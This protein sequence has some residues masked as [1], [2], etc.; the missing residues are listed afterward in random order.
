MS[1]VTSPCIWR[2]Y[3]WRPQAKGVVLGVIRERPPC[4]F[5]ISPALC[6]QG[7]VVTESWSC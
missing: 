3:T 1:S 7:A 4:Q 2:R 5:G 6:S